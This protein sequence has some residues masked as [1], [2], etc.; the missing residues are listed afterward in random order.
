M[1]GGGSC[2]FKHHG[3]GLVGLWCCSTL[4]RIIPIIAPA[5]ASE[6]FLVQSRLLIVKCTCLMA[7]PAS[8]VATATF[9]HGQIP[10]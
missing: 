3:W 5:L 7:K 1:F 10:I 4:P 6:L 9:L 8:L 2:K